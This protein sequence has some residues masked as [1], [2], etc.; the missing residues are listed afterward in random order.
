MSNSTGLTHILDY[1]DISILGYFDARPMIYNIKYIS[2]YYQQVVT[3]VTGV[4]RSTLSSQGNMWDNSNTNTHF[5]VLSC[6]TL[7]RKFSK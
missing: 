5:N 6:F 3:G 2:F 4:Q 7:N 1:I